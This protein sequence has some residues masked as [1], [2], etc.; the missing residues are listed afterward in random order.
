MSAPSVAFVDAYPHLLGGG[1]RTVVRAARALIERGG[2]ATVIVPGDGPLADASR[3]A[4][5]DVEVVTIPRALQHY[6]Q[7]TTGA[8]AARAVPALPLAWRAFSVAF[9]CGSYD[10][11]HINDHRGLLLAAPAARRAHLPIVWHA[12][13]VDVDGRRIEQSVGRLVDT[14]IAPSRAAVGALTGLDRRVP[15]AV[16]H[17]AIDDDVL[18][19]HRSPPRRDGRIVTVAR[20]HPAKGLDVAIRAVA[21]LVAD[22]RA[23]TLD[24]Y[25]DPQPG[26]EDHAHALA[27][28]VDSLGVGHTVHF[29]RGVDRPH[30]GWLDADVYVQPSRAETFGLAAAEAMAIGVP[31]VVARVGGLPELVDDGRTGVVVPPDDPSALASAIA[32]LLDDPA[33]ADALADA[34]RVR[35]RE[36]TTDRFADALMAIWQRAIER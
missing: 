20:L 34:A 13:A 23:V 11:A 3:A 19:L 17:G 4:G 22:G 27:L 1:Q 2:R 36:L 5:A 26:A 35:A 10:L 14:A 12:H 16:V 28:L 18:A 24:V 21:S 33:L 9:R 15:R 29:H 32:A 30:A 6:G 25:G 7:T 8:R 31:V